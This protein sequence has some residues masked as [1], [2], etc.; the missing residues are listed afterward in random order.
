MEVF[1]TVIKVLLIL[2]AIAGII[3]GG[4]RTLVY[5]V[6]AIVFLVLKIRAKVILRKDPDSEK[7]RDLI[8]FAEKNKA[9]FHDVGLQY[10]IMVAIGLL[11]YGLF[12]LIRYFE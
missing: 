3:G 8:A 7:A 11:C 9:K 12:E 5:L 2:F 6:L 10:V 4:K 1:L